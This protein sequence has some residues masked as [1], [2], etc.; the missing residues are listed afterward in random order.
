MI[1]EKEKENK[2]GLMVLFTKEI[3]LKIC[4]MDKGSLQMLMVMYMKVNTEMIKL[5]VM[6]FLLKRMDQL[7][8]EIGIKIFM[9]D[10]GKNN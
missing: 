6:E 2:H 4:N 1:F 3:G 7:I 8:K 10:K 9:M 5:M